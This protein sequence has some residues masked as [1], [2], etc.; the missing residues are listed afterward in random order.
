MR[1]SGVKRLRLVPLTAVIFFIVCGGAFGIESSV[2]S[3]GAGW[4]I[5]L[6]VATPIVWALPIALM[7]AELSSMMPNEGGYYVWVRTAMGDFWAVQQGWW[8]VCYTLIDLAIYPVLFVN[9]LAYFFPYLD[10]DQNGSARFTVL[11]LRWMIATSIIGAALFINLRGAKAVGRNSIVNAALVI[12]PFLI[13]SFI[14]F[15]RD[16]ASSNIITAIRTSLGNTNGFVPLSVGLATLM[17]NYSGW[18]SSSTFAGEVERAKRNY[19]LALLAAL[20][21]SMLSYLVPVLGGLTVTADPKYWTESAGWPV[22]GELLAGPWL[23]LLMAVAALLSAWSLL[24]SNLLY[25]SRLPFAMACDQWLPEFLTYVSPRS[26]AP[27]GSL[28]FTCVLASGLSALSFSKLIVMDATLSLA[29]LMLQFGALVVLRIKQ[30]QLERPFKIP[31]GWIAVTIIILLP[32]FCG[33]VLL[34]ATLHDETSLG[35]ILLI[36][37]IVLTGP[38][39]Y[40]LRQNGQGRSDVNLPPFDDERT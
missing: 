11:V 37:G 15:W 38:G 25:V 35:Q 18:D 31:G 17:W 1:L 21:I 39:L 4:A 13:L 2:G 20:S 19:P 9:Y 32:M 40:A 27:I 16:G 24:N 3:L 22:I 33:A 30:P 12:G 5:I 34:Y 10:L 7:V 36:G 26:Q 23:G 14:G 29:A 6:I 28:L 8:T